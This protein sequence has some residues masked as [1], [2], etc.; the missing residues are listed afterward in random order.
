ML[1]SRLLGLDPTASHRPSGEDIKV[2][3]PM[4]VLLADPSFNYHAPPFLPRSMPS[5]EKLCCTTPTGDRL[6]QMC[7]SATK[8]C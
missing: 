4:I 6:G 8:A 2:G 5:G 1:S 3:A 7:W